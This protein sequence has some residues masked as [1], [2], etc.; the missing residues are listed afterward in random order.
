[1]EGRGERLSQQQEGTCQARFGAAPRTQSKD[2]SNLCRAEASGNKTA[3]AATQETTAPPGGFSCPGTTLGEWRV[4][5][6]AG[7]SGRGL[8]SSPRGSRCGVGS[9][10]PPC[11]QGTEAWVW[12]CPSSMGPRTASWSSRCLE[13][14][15]LPLCLQGPSISAPAGK[16]GELEPRTLAKD[17]R[18]ALCCRG[19]S[20]GP[21]PPLPPPTVFQ[22]S[23]H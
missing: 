10:A 21:S 2:M 20:G 13:H 17:P 18:E 23:A 19:D 6:P 5:P 15:H 7:G 1:M 3:S 14:P 22:M 9:R 4:L 8:A 12:T 16:A 11:G